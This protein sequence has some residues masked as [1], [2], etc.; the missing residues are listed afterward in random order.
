M[1]S[2]LKVLLFTALINSSYANAASV[3]LQTSFDRYNAVACDSITQSCVALGFESDENNQKVTRVSY[4]SEDGGKSWQQSVKLPMPQGD[5]EDE[6]DSAALSCD[7]SAVKC[8]A[9]HFVIINKMPQI[10]VYKTL[11]GGKSWTEPKL[12]ATKVN[13]ND[14]KILLSNSNN[15]EATFVSASCDPSATNCVISGGINTSKVFVPVIY[16]TQDSAEN[17]S[18]AKKLIPPRH[19]SPSNIVHG[20]TLLDVACDQTG[21]KCLTVG[22]TIAQNN[23]FNDYYASL[24]VVYSSSNGGKSWNK[25]QK[26]PTKIKLHRGDTLAGAACDLSGEKCSVVGYTVHGDT[27]QNQTFVFKSRNGGEDWG[28]KVLIPTK[29]AAEFP[30]SFK[31]DYA[32]KRCIITG[33]YSIRKSG[34]ILHKPVYY[35]TDNI[36][37]DKWTR[38]ILPDTGFSSSILKKVACDNKLES[39][40]AVGYN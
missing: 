19:R 22:N 35:V 4:A 5:A 13:R 36:K 32:N 12:L 31:C 21:K 37:K 30:T 15:L 39:C 33:Y 27:G 23:V 18:A 10:V 2:A 20:T 1:K 14:R 9:A 40:V 11:D 24:P 6:I 38:H 34:I 3:N 16:S 26:L 28:K 25:P 29:E 8:I 7:E 17:W